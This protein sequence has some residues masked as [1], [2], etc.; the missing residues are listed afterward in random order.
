MDMLNTLQLAAIHAWSTDGPGEWWWLWRI[1]MFLI[2][3]V[4]LF[5]IFRWAGRGWR[6]EPSP[7][8][9][10]RGILAERYARGEIDAAEY[11]QRSETLQ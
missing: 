10:A 8:D 11:R 9:R 3:I 1:A 2:W 5:F 7:M 6:R 4:V